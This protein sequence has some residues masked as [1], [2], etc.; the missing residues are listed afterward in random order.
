MDA[1]VA[2]GGHDVAL[3][4]F[5]LHD[6]VVFEF[7]AVLALL[8]GHLGATAVDIV[9]VDGAVAL[10]PLPVLVVDGADEVRGGGWGGFAEEPGEHGGG[11]SGVALRTEVDPVDG[12]R[13][14]GGG[15]GGEGRF[16]EIDEDGAIGGGDLLHG[17]GV[18]AEP[19]VGLGT[20]GEVGVVEIFVGD[21]GEEDDFGSAFA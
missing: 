10:V 2:V 14:F 17:F 7:R 21:G 18:V 20:V 5:L 12:E 11:E 16:E 3:G 19:V 13:F 6:L 4:H 8:I 9:A 1:G 15:V